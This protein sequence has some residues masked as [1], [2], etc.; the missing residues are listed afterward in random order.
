MTIEEILR[1]APEQADITSRKSRNHPNSQAASRSTNRARDCA[2]IEEYL[3][4]VGN[5]TVWEISQALA[6]PYQSAS[7]RCSDMKYKLKT[8]EET[9]ERRPTGT[10]NK[11]S[12]LRL[13]GVKNG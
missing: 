10:G 6:M 7:A 5:A 4:K 13:N 9:G 8:V 11:A 2:R 12:V 3:K 1:S